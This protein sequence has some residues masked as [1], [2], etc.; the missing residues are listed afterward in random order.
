MESICL[1]HV[2]WKA[3]CELYAS[4]VFQSV[5]LF[6]YFL[7][8]RQERPSWLSV[9]GARDSLHLYVLHVGVLSYFLRLNNHLPVW[10]QTFYHYA[11]PLVILLLTLLLIRCLRKVR[12]LR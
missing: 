2:G 11:A 4:S 7:S 1:A 5:C 6:L 8:V 12:I 9:S 3:A 10:W